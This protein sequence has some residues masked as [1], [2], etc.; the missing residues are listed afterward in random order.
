MKKIISRNQ[1]IVIA[2][3]GIIIMLVLFST[4]DFSKPL[5]ELDIPNC[6][7]WDIEKEVDNNIRYTIPINVF[8]YKNYTQSGTVVHSGSGKDLAETRI[9]RQR[10][11]NKIF[12]LGTERVNIISEKTARYGIEQLD[13]ILFSNPLINDNHIT[14]VCEGKAEDIMKYQSKE[15]S[16]PG[17]YLE[18][19]VENMQ[20]YSFYS[21]NYKAIDIMVRQKAEGRSI[22]LPYVLINDGKLQIE[23]MAIFKKDKMIGRLNIKDAAILN[24]LK[25]DGVRGALSIDDSSNNSISYEAVTKK[26]VKCVKNKDTGKYEYTI[27]IEFNGNIES[28]TLYKDLLTKP[29]V[30]EK[31]QEDMENDI[32]NKCNRF[33]EKMQKEYKTD[34]LELGRFSAAKYGR[35]KEKDWDEVVS[36]SKI[37]VIAEVKIK[38]LNRSEY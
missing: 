9:D 7:G 35:N 27:N 38:L 28:N 21:E 23:G 17:E 24:I 26:K 15:Y 32:E 14:I 36:N 19:L 25:E 30:Q 8:I 1:K 3:I 12:L 18:G 31:F 2:A 22:S 13:N 29:K 34:L 16:S 10:R 5:E 4:K 20:N 33:I 11:S 6:I 37:K